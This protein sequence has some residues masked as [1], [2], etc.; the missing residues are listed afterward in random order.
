MYM[1]TIKVV[2]F[3]Y[4]VLSSCRAVSDETREMSWPLAS[5]HDHNRILRYKSSGKATSR[6]HA[7]RQ[8][9]VLPFREGY[10]DNVIEISHYVTKF[11]LLN[12][13]HGNSLGR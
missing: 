6:E 10:E 12:T 1:I 5:L 13:I 9:A 2:F 7:A 8:C 3:V 11:L 4:G